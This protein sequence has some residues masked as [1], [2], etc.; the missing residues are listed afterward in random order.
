[1]NRRRLL[2]GLTT[3][4]T[5]PAIVQ[6]SSLMNIKALPTELSAIE[7]LAG[8]KP[9]ERKF[10]AHVTFSEETLAELQA[11]IMRGDPVGEELARLAFKDSVKVII[12]APKSL[13]A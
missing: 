1:M 10:L 11:S 13:F 12:D 2:I 4:I 9:I 8:W 3:F 7:V 5:A 6:A